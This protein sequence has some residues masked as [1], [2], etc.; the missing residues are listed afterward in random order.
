MNLKPVLL[1]LLFLISLHGVFAD[2]GSIENLL[3]KPDGS[4]GTITAVEVL[5]T[6]ISRKSFIAGEVSGR[7]TETIL[8]ISKKPLL[9]EKSWGVSVSGVLVTISSQKA[10]ITDPSK[11]SVYIDS[12]GRPMRIPPLIR[13]M[14]INWPKVSLAEL[15]ETPKGSSIMSMGFV[16]AKISIGRRERNSSSFM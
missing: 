10:L 6:G 13:E 3:A 4:F 5:S 8:V 1:I 16:L 2:A 12:A 15:T 14:G 7:R 11:V 9:A